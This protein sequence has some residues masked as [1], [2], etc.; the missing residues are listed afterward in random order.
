MKAKEKKTALN[1]NFYVELTSFTCLQSA[2]H[3][4]TVW[5]FFSLVP[6]LLLVLL[7]FYPSTFHF[8]YTFKHFLS[9]VFV[10]DA[11]LCLFKFFVYSFYLQMMRCPN[12]RGY[13][14]SIQRSSSL[15]IMIL[16]S[17]WW[18]IGKFN[19]RICT[20]FHIKCMHAQWLL[21][22]YTAL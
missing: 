18:V 3:Q 17:M 5:V 2:Y 4:H 6:L 1:I 14:N 20:Y 12:S 7:I 15:N 8:R 21:F 11:I 10:N 16:N 13:T 9:I 22:K 19:V